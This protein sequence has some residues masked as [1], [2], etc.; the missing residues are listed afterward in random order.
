MTVMDLR[1]PTLVPEAVTIT[2]HAMARYSHRRNSL[3]AERGLRR[4]LE[5]ASHRPT[6]PLTIQAD[7]GPRRKVLVGGFVLVFDADMQTLVTLWRCG[8]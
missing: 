3:A 6:P 4:L 2:D 5:R 7:H 1:P 8:R